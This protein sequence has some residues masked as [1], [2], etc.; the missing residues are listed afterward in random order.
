[1]GIVTQR[2]AGRICKYTGIFTK[3]QKTSRQPCKNPISLR[4]HAPVQQREA[5][6]VNRSHD[7]SHPNDIIISI[8]QYNLW[9]HMHTRGEPGISSYRQYGVGGTRASPRRRQL[10]G[11]ESAFQ[12]RPW[13]L[14]HNPNPC[15]CTA[16]ASPCTDECPNAPTFTCSSQLNTAMRPLLQPPSGLVMLPLD[17]SAR[18]TNTSPADVSC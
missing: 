14:T 1:M 2:G 13:P 15:S 8:H 10:T 6:C 17:Q 9:E 18:T 12:R 16:Y 11:R 3:C 7:N 5:D 4:I